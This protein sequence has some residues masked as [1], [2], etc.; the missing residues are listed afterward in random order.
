MKKSIIICCA[1]FGVL[2]P[3]FLF[4][5]KFNNLNNTIALSPSTRGMIAYSNAKL[6]AHIELSS[7]QD[8]VQSFERDLQMFYIN[9]I[10]YEP[11]L[12]VQNMFNIDSDNIQLITYE[13]L[14]EHY[15]I[16]PFDIAEALDGMEL[17]YGGFYGSEYGI[18][19]FP[20]GG[21]YDANSFQY[22]RKDTTQH[23]SVIVKSSGFTGYII[24]M[25][26][27]YDSLLTS[28]INGEEMAIVRYTDN[29]GFAPSNDDIWIPPYSDMY[30]TKFIYK[31]LGFFVTGANLSES[32]FIKVLQ[33]LTNI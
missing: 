6:T 1:I 7:T 25:I 8:C 5:Q 24:D 20:S 10:E 21:I 16:Q 2:F 4:S 27:N 19:R 11:N 30:Y 13:E 15:G 12:R 14:F 28:K 18:Y 26:E 3:T 32:D 33:H 31:G 29:V 17:I 23:I 22:H 9:E